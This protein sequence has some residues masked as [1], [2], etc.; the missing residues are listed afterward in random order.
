MSELQSV[1]LTQR[2]DR[3]KGHQVDRDRF[4][5]I[6]VERN[7]SDRIWVVIRAPPP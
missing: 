2:D 7:L 5:L 1:A 3:E 4:G 6:F